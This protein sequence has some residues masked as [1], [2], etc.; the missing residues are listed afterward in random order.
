MKTQER[1]KYVSIVFRGITKTQ[2]GVF[3]FMKWAKIVLGEFKQMLM[4]WQINIIQQILSISFLACGNNTITIYNLYT[5][6]F[7]YI[8][9]MHA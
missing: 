3:K 4:R 9:I 8:H 1:G 2:S 5:Y 7:V 6:T